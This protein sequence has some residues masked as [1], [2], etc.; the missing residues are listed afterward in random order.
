MSILDD[1]TKLIVKFCEERDWAQFHD[2]K[3]LAISLS[4]E[5]SEVLELFQ[6]KDYH[7]INKKELAEELADVYYWILLMSHY[8]EIDIGSAF[9]AKMKQNKAK[10]PIEKAKGKKDKYTNYQ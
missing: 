9:A 1:H 7:E 6:W 10:Y 3:D 5:A 8:L 2:P 4:L